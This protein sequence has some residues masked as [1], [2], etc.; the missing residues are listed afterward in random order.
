MLD[1]IPGNAAALSQSAFGI[2]NVNLVLFGLPAQ[3]VLG[4]IQQ[5]DGPVIAQPGHYL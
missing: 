1:I 4:I 3:Q 2:D 5:R